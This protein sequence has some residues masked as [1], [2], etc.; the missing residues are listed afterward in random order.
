MLKKTLL[1]FSIGMTLLSSCSKDDEVYQEASQSTAQPTVN[2]N[3]LISDMLYAETDLRAGL[4]KASRWNTG[5]I[6]RVKFIGGND[7]LRLKVKKYM[8]EWTCY[9][10]LNFVFV[11]SNENATI[12]IRFDNSNQSY[13]YVGTDCKYITDQN[14]PTVNFGWF[15]NN[16]PE[17]EFQRVIRHEIGH[18][19]G[20]IH[21]HQTP[22]AN[23]QW[24]T[25]VVY[26]WGRETQ[27]WSDATTYTNIIEKY[28]AT[29]TNYSSFDR[30][31]IMTYGIPSNWTTNNVSVPSNNKLSST[32][33]SYIGQWYPYGNTKRLFRCWIPGMQDHFYTTSFD[34]LFASNVS[35][36]IEIDMG[37]VYTQQVSGTTPLYRYWNP[38]IQDHFY[39]TYYSELGS[40]KMD[41]VYEG[42][43]GYVY[44]GPRSNCMAVYRYWNPS[45]GD[46]FYTNNYSELG[47]GKL[48]Y[49]YE[50]IGFYLLNN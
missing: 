46:H 13:S 9:A 10:N 1:L 11:P 47:S 32:D 23:I 40:G 28:T 21:E 31:S 38:K 18:V 50:G 3:P 43:V 22:A 36:C 29:E 6:I 49:V 42:V 25:A 17:D 26:K 4:V 2:E 15:N 5:E 19:L 34:E 16:T 14:T 44:N 30:L 20:L 33:K 24:N 37:R 39:T 45:A 35:D 7:Y 8:Y 41:Y 12:R 48:G 27:G